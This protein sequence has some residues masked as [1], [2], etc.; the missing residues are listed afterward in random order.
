MGQYNKDP[1][2][3]RHQVIGDGFTDQKLFDDLRELFNNFGDK[4][5]QFS[6]GASSNANESMNASIV[7]KAPESRVYG[8]SSS[9][10]ARVVLKR[11]E[12]EI[13]VSSLNVELNSSPGK[14]TSNYGTKC[15]MI[16]RKKYTKSLSQESKR[17]RLFLKQK[18]TELKKKMELNEG[19]TDC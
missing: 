7:S 19:I 14:H 2:T 12:G 1:S 8:T 18:R 13:Y 10:D 15:D 17:R 4:S 5:E 16:S 6:A 11:N 3:Y 9:A